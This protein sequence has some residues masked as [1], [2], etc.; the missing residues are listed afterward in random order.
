MRIQAFVD[1]V[2]IVLSLY[3]SAKTIF[4]VVTVT[5]MSKGCGSRP[6]VYEAHPNADA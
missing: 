1:F 2:V 4:L 3:K 5:Y 6:R